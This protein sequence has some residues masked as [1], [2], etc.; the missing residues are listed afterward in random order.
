[1]TQWEI[2]PIFRALMRNKV[3][4]V[5]I[6]IQIAVT[7]TIVVNSIFIIIE[8]AELMDRTSGI[9]EDNSFYLTTT[10]FGENFD[11]KSTAVTRFG[12]DTQHTRCD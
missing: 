5:L 1:M 12:D 4:A 9:D 10:G 3:G 8:R 11:A 2:G 7:M 6:A